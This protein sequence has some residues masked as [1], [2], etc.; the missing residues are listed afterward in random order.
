M[1]TVPPYRRQWFFCSTKPIK[2]LLL[3]IFQNVKKII[4]KI[5]N[6]DFAQLVAEDD[7]FAGLFTA[8]YAAVSNRMEITSSATP[9]A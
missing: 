3:N 6:C 4:K 2:I 9:I 5:L 1:L 7:A 8:K